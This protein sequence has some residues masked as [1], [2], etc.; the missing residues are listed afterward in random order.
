ML[1]AEDLLLLL[2]DDHTGKLV[3][4]ASQVDTALGGAQLVELSLAERVDLDH[5]R[6]IRV[7]D[8]S[9]TG[10]E[11]LD[12]ALGMLGRRQGQKPSGV[13]GP[14]GK[15]LRDR[16]YARL[17]SAGILR[18]EEGRVLGIFPSRSWP[19][20]SFDHEAAVRRALVDTLV[21]QAPPD[22]RTGALVSLVHALRATHKVVDPREHGLPRRDLDRR[23]KQVADGDWGSK[24]VRQAIDEMTAAVTA[25]VTAGAVAAGSS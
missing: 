3:V 11:L 16:L 18:A 1:L 8:A 2:T 7:N 25:A 10:D 23:A 22:P 5:R 17:A 24:A 15:K 14:L 13:V 4:S 19:A 20:S 6:R 12:A 21:H 9:P